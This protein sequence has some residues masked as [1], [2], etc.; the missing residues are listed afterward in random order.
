MGPSQTLKLVCLLCSSNSIAR[1]HPAAASCAKNLGENLSGHQHLPESSIMAQ[2]IW[3][4]EAEP[5]FPLLD[6]PFGDLSG[7]LPSR[8]DAC[9]LVIW[10]LG[11]DELAQGP[12]IWPLGPVP[13]GAATLSAFSLQPMRLRVSIKAATG[14]FVA[15]HGEAIVCT[16]CPSS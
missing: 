8:L 7:A 11:E 12:A 4:C 9:P 13:A 6:W 15:P 16:L 2:R 5:D 1:R 14:C 3:P 10:P